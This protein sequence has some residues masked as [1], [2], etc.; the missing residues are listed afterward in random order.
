MKIKSFFLLSSIA[1]T[2]FV[3]PLFASQ[4]NKGFYAA[5]GIGPD[6]Y[7]SVDGAFEP[8]G[9]AGDDGNK[10]GLDSAF[11]GEI[12]VGYDFGN[13]IR[14]EIS[15]IRSS[16][17][18]DDLYI[19]DM[20]GHQ[21]P[22]DGEIKLDVFMISAYKDFYNK[23]KFTPYLGLGLGFRSKYGRIDVTSDALGEYDIEDESIF[24][25]QLKVGSSYEVND[26]A[27]IYVEGVYL[28][29]GETNL[30]Y[31]GGAPFD[32]NFDNLNAFGLKAGLRWKF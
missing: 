2:T 26:S 23:S 31:P 28:N 20:G 22:T 9:I 29:T 18:V 4:S 11:S 5:I 30:K 3:S 6:F 25:Y 8:M 15:Y 24:S 10:L 27:N 14:S 21:G 13:S 16:V 7:S 1:I 17:P 32:L 12:S 19:K